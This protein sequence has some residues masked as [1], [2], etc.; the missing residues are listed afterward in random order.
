M[1]QERSTT[2][3]KQLLKLIEDPKTATFGS[4]GLK[5]KGHSLFSI[6]ALK[7]RISF[8]KERLAFGFSFKN[9]SFDVRVV[10]TILQLCIFVLVVYFG[11]NLVFSISSSKIP[12]ISQDAAASIELGSPQEVSFLKKE[13][14]YLE[15]ARSRD[16]FR[17]GQ[18]FEQAM[19]EAEEVDPPEDIELLP[20]KSEEVYERFSLVGIAWSDDPDAMIE[21]LD[22][23]KIHFLK[24]GETIQDVK[25]QG[26][27]KDRVVLLYKGEEIELR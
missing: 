6:A 22:T 21:D 15:N 2:P 7:G 25:I 24:R 20:S 8:F 27:L 14:Y 16:I 1:A 18:F 26:I 11:V 12:E 13:S 9:I 5:H 10:S 4:K 17:F 19:E 23:E 3:E